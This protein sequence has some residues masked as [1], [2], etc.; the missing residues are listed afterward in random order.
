LS[1]N[2]F[3]ARVKGESITVGID[4]GH[5]GVKIAV[6]SHQKNSRTLLSAGVEQLP[7]DAI[8]EGDVRAEHAD[9]VATAIRGLI[10]SH[11]PEGRSFD[12]VAGINWAQGVI[13]DRVNIKVEKGDDE[14]ERIIG[15]ASRRSPFDEQDIT[16]DY[17]VLNRNESTGFVE[18]LLLAAK[19]KT[20]ERWAEFYKS[21]GLNLRAMDVDSI[22]LVNA[23][24]GTRPA[25]ELAGQI[26]GLVN[27]GKSKSHLTMVRDG[28]YHSTRE[29]QNASVNYIEE[30]LARKLMVDKEKAAGILQGIGVTDSSDEQDLQEVLE[31][32]A[33]EISVGIDLALQYYRS[34]EKQENVDRIY[35]VGG[36]ANINGM[37]ELLSDK[38]EDVPVAVLDPLAHIQYDP[39]Q[40]GGTIP[41]ELSN[42]LA[43]ALGRALRKF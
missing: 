41:L 40:F 18:V 34:V 36:G 27:I 10:A 38:L 37:A 9:E 14:E 33:E 4:L 8:S 13:G 32:A 28:K 12:V 19:N 5:S 11:I 21:L 16:M 26:I 3:L 42:T 43:V 24:L 29:V 15:D 17:E 35:I 23:L 1:I 20:L 22:S 25:S 7:P 39:V 31:H 2:D 6:I 30:L